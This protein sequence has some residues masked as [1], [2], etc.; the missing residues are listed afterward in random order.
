MSDVS[1][2]EVAHKADADKGE[3]KNEEFLVIRPTLLF[4]EERPDHVVDP[5]NYEEWEVRWRQVQYEP[6]FMSGLQAVSWMWSNWKSRATIKQATRP[7]KGIKTHISQTVRNCI[8]NQ[9]LP[10]SELGYG[11]ARLLAISFL[12]LSHEDLI[13]G[14]G[15]G[16]IKGCFGVCSSWFSPSLQLDGVGVAIILSNAIPSSLLALETH[17]LLHLYTKTTLWWKHT[18]FFAIYSVKYNVFS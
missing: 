15:C 17:I 10:L 9:T 8:R 3:H 12:K 4:V 5:E 18:M 11:S 13:D 6:L 16:G 1:I 7:S 14:E 2:V